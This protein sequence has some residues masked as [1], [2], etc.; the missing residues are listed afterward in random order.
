MAI[1]QASQFV[2]FLCSDFQDQL[3]TFIIRVTET[4][5]SWMQKIQAE[6]LPETTT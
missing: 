4:G 5:R 2:Q 1:L 3:T 6:L